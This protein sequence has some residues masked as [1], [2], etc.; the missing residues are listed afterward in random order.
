MSVIAHS[1]MLIMQCKCICVH[2]K[3]EACALCMMFIAISTTAHCT[4]HT[5]HCTLSSGLHTVQIF[6]VVHH[7]IHR[8]Q[9]HLQEGVESV[10]LETFRIHKSCAVFG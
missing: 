8:G 2:F 6:T 10:D 3:T 5:A 4:L 1:A 9:K 7:S